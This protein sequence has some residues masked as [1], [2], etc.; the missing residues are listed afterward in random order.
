MCVVLVGQFFSDDG[1]PGGC[2]H[3]EEVGGDGIGVYIDLIL[4]CV[5]DGA[6]VHI[7]HIKLRISKMDHLCDAV[8]LRTSCPSN[9]PIIEER[10]CFTVT[11]I[12]L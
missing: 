9:K 1:I 3:G 2:L 10:K 6:G 5:S 11:G 12:Y 8:P 4:F 7:V